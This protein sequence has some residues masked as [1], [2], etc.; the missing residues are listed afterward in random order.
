M[1]RGVVNVA[2]GKAAQA[3]QEL[4]PCDLQVTQVQLLTLGLGLEQKVLHRTRQAVEEPELDLGRS[5][6]GGEPAIDKGK[7]GGADG[8]GAK[9]RK[10]QA[11]A[12]REELL[13]AKKTEAER[14][15]RVSERRLGKGVAVVVLAY[16]WKKLDCGEKTQEHHRSHQGEPHGI[17]FGHGDLGK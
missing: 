5:Q 10:V 15:G 13:R 2:E 6:G 3:A 4:A 1:P 11:Q 14:E 17:R 9:E 7:R 16:L 8:K 12:D